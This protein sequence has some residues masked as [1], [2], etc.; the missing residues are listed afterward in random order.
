M[1]VVSGCL[2][3]GILILIDGSCGIS[4]SLSCELFVAKA[5]VDCCLNPSF[6][7]KLHNVDFVNSV[8]LHLLAGI[9]QGRTFSHQLFGYLEMQFIQERPDK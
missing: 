8:L 2:T 3:L 6:P 4:L 9:P 5:S 7:Q 1:P